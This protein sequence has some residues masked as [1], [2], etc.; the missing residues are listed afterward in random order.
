MSKTLPRWRLAAPG[1]FMLLVGLGGC[2]GL[3]R[4]IVPPDVQ[5]VSLSLI[6]ATTDGQRFRLGFLLRNA[7]DFPVPVQSVR[8]SARLGGEGVLTGES[9]GLTLPA[10]GEERLRVE[11]RT[12]LVSSI[13]RLLSLVQG[14]EDG[15]SYELAGR[16]TL[17]GRPPRTLPF[18]HSGLV[19]LSASMGAR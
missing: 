19:P 5:L 17:D 11:V 6:E 9:L 16:I 14:P 8:F 13:T 18:A 10:G 3:P 1:L 2:S 4:S 15:L 7:N 12:E